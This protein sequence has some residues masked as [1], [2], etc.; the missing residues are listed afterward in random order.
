[1]PES[2]SDR[3]QKLRNILEELDEDERRLF[4]EVL[5]AEQKKLHM[6][7]PRNIN[8]DLWKALTE[9]IR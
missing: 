1:M 7:P 4:S 6:S 5:K 8:E 9:T 3:Q 2:A